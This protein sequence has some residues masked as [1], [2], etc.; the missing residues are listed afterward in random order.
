MINYP[1]KKK[2]NLQS[3]SNYSNQR[4]MGLEKDI[5]DSNRFY[6]DT[7]QALIYKKPTP[8]QVV[9]VDY[10]N[11]SSAK[12]VE[13]YYK[14][15][16]TTDYNGIY[17]GKYIDFEAKETKSKVSFTFKNIH[18]H[19]IQHLRDVALHGG[20][21]FVIIRFSAYN[22]TYLIDGSIIVNAYLDHSQKSISYKKVKECGY[23]IAESF[24]PRLKYLNI[25]DTLY[26]KEDT[27]GF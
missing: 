13:G 4:G 10:P 21:A 12:I 2:P 17:R 27:Y 16:S 14:T 6:R 8:V 18:E 5:N 19:Q 15:P 1:N 7:K 3:S 20:I 9:R 23:L 26:F 11:R 24:S 25:V 22:E